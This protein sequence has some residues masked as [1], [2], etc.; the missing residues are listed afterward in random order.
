MI[1]CSK[2]NIGFGAWG[3]GCGFRVYGLYKDIK[4]YVIRMFWVEGFR[5][6]VSEG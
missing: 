2:G 5:V 1:Q 3:F 6:K 4:A